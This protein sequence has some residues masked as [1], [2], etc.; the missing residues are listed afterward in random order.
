MGRKNIVAIAHRSLVPPPFKTNDPS[1]VISSRMRIF[2]HS[3]YKAAVR[4]AFALSIEY[5]YCSV[6]L[7]ILLHD[8]VRKQQRLK[9]IPLIF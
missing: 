3:S 2:V 1:L 4:L 9:H 5:L 8:E 6:P 7:F